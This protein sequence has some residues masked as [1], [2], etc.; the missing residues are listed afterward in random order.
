MRC[1]KKI[2]LEVNLYWSA[3][4]FEVLDSNGEALLK[5]NPFQLFSRDDMVATCVCISLSL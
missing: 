2:D 5:L 3:K 4:S 1:K